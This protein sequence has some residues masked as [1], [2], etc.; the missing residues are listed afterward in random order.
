VTAVTLA[1][2][3][4][5]PVQRRVAVILLAAVAVS[6]S[7]NLIFTAAFG[8]VEPYFDGWHWIELL[9]DYRAGTIGSIDLLMTIHNEHPY[10]LATLIFIWLG[11][12]VQYRFDILGYPVPFLLAVNTL[13]IASLAWKAG[14]RS[15]ILFVSVAFL[16]ASLRQA[17][18]FVDTFD[19]GLHLTVLLGLVAVTATVCFLNT[20]K[21][22]PRLSWLA[23]LFLSLAGDALSSAGAAGA[24]PAIVFL[25]LA[26][27]ASGPQS[28]LVRLGTAVCIGLLCL[29]WFN[30]FFGVGIVRPPVSGTRPPFSEAPLGLLLI[31]GGSLFANRSI[32]LPAGAV[33][34]L[35][36]G[37]LALT[38]WRRG[39]Y[40]RGLITAGLFS[41]SMI[42]TVAAARGAMGGINPGR[43]A[44]YAIPLAV[45][46]LC[47][48][49]ERLAGWPA[50]V[51]HVVVGL[52]IITI[53]ASLW[54]SAV[55]AWKIGR[56]TQVWEQ[57]YGDIMLNYRDRSPAEIAAFDPWPADQA[58]AHIAYL[59]SNRLN[60]FF[61]PSPPIVWEKLEVED[62]T[63]GGASS[64]ERR[65]DGSVVMHGPNHIFSQLSCPDPVCLTRLEV[66]VISADTANIG[67]IFLDKSGKWTENFSFPID[68]L[69]ERPVMVEFSNPNRDAVSVAG[70]VYAAKST[71]FVRFRDFSIALR[72]PSGPSLCKRILCLVPLPTAQ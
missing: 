25:L 29:F 17:E 19:L 43:Y 35:A 66:T 18:S 49:G 10:G 8:R 59:E 3:P 6:T 45:T 65:Q 34:V 20:K 5:T 53:A 23:L 11:R 52:S 68:G 60:L 48:V 32:A 62:W 54:L 46:T 28:R 51:Q 21:G 57:V 41:L 24:F 39:P 12:L 55:E 2:A 67:V 47:L 30:Y 69:K 13:L 7:V 72:Q 42:V 15:A 14:M 22:W 1:S 63:K 71:D 4:R 50:R 27:P 70:Y 36:F 40:H 9:R 56:E 26:S 64:W 58:R 37:W 33:I 16:A 31:A 38:G 61:K 44:I